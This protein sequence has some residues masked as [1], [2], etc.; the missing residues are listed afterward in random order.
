MLVFMHTS[1]FAKDAVKDPYYSPQTSFAMPVHTNYTPELVHYASWALKKM[2]KP[3]YRYMKCGV[4]LTELVQEGNH[5][6]DLFDARDEKRQSKLMAA[7]DHINARWGRGRC[8]MRA[9]A[10]TGR[11]SAR[12]PRSLR[13]IPRTGTASSQCWRSK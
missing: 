8:F 1:P 2:Y 10:S 12:R 9:L 3:G 4:M 11:G 7:M 5:T 6:G 13:R